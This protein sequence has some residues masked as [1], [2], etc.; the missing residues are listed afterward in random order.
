MAFMN[1]YHFYR[2]VYEQIYSK[3]LPSFN[4][5][6]V[7]P[8]FFSLDSR[9]NNVGSK[10]NRMMLINQLKSFYKT[11]IRLG[12]KGCWQSMISVPCFRLLMKL[13]A[14]AGCFDAFSSLNYLPTKEIR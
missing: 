1:V 9:E 7:C 13:S 12:W 11:A 14:P 8:S 2:R 5:D 3:I 6:I 10:V 4:A